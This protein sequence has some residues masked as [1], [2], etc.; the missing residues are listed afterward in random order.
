MAAS[1]AG[2]A[3]AGHQ[4]QPRSARRGRFDTAE[5]TICRCCAPLASCTFGQRPTGAMEP[6]PEPP[7]SPADAILNVCRQLADEKITL[8][9]AVAHTTAQRASLDKLDAELLSRL[10]GALCDGAAATQSPSDGRD[11]LALAV[12]CC[13]VDGVSARRCDACARGGFAGEVCRQ[14]A[15]LDLRGLQF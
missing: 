15:A 10:V 3:A 12:E 11:A 7:P 14:A 13:A 9:E 4:T 6:L 1:D 5:G 8:A 2:P